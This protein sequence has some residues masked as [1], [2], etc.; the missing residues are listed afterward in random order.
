MHGRCP[1][2]RG[3]ERETTKKSEGDFS[4]KWKGRFSD[5]VVVVVVIFF[6]FNC[7]GEVG[8]FCCCPFFV[9]TSGGF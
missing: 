1:S 4:L 2:T 6:C 5:V 9:S 3:W 8:C 7:M